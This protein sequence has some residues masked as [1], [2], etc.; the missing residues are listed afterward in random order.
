MKTANN[1]SPSESK[2]LLEKL[3]QMSE[4]ELDQFVLA[5]NFLIG[6]VS[7]NRRMKGLPKLNGGW[8]LKITFPPH[9]AYRRSIFIIPADANNVEKVQMWEKGQEVWAQRFDLPE[10]YISRWVLVR[11]KLKHSLLG[12]TVACLNCPRLT[13]AY[14]SYDHNFNAEETATWM[15]AYRITDNLGVLPRVSLSKI[16]QELVKED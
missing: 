16:I 1:L 5:G 6:R 8:R 14:L 15:S 7:Y 2:S 11:N 13:E 4:S 12:Y 3:S 9:R 10:K